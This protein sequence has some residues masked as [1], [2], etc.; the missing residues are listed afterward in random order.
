[1]QQALQGTFQEQGKKKIKPEMIF[2]EDTF[3]K[4]LL[5]IQQQIYFFRKLIFSAALVLEVIF[6]FIFPIWILK[7][8]C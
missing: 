1:L 5:I 7:S 2:I 3:Y 8:L 6:P 4:K